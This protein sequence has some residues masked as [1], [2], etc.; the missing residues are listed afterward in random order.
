M[1]VINVTNCWV[2]ASRGPDR[3]N[4]I[5]PALRLDL[6]EA[7]R[8]PVR[9][10]GLVMSRIRHGLVSALPGGLPFVGSVLGG[11]R[12]DLPPELRE[13]PGPSN[14]SYVVSP[15]DLLACGESPRLET[16]P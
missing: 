8:G 4:K 5:S 9:M 11:L 3:G 14:G 10:P 2:A 13:P 12:G 7:H 6:V 15:A 16:V 1:L